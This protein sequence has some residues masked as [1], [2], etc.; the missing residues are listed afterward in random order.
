MIS[1]IIAGVAAVGAAGMQMKASKDAA[2]AGSKLAGEQGAAARQT[3]AQER[4][5]SMH[6]VEKAEAAIELGQ[7]RV[8]SSEIGRQYLMEGLGAPGTYEQSYED[9][10]ADQGQGILGRGAG[11]RSAMFRKTK[12]EIST[13]GAGLINQET[14]EAGTAHSEVTDYA[15]NPEQMAERTQASRTGRMMSY[16]TAQADQLL[17][18]EGP[19]YQQIKESVQGPIMEGAG[20]ARQT[21]MENIRVQAAKGGSA[22]NR[23]VQAATELAGEQQIQRER[24]NQ[25]WQTNLK[26]IELGINNAD[27]QRKANEEWINNRAGI[28]DDFNKMMNQFTEMRVDSILDAEIGI[29]NNMADAQMVAQGYDAKAK[30]ALID[31]KQNSMLLAAGAVSTVGGIAS[32]GY[33]SWSAG[34]EADEARGIADAQRDFASNRDLIN[35]QEWGSPSRP[36][37]GFAGK[38]SQGGVS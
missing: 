2:K 12:K 33:Q 32:K 1:A 28:R 23:A 27:R 14:G 34:R 35:R 10:Y 5:A 3:A 25:L 7:E 22:R 11:A 21:M 24:Q 30:Q 29:A 16:M 8:V 13:P 4:A 37:Y 20:I 9:Y 36:G 38:G 6:A 18:Q 26:I 31:G 19:L 17:R 15:V